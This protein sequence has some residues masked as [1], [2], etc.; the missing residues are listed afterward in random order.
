MKTPKKSILIAF[1][2]GLV[3]FYSCK[4]AETPPNS[5]AGS[6]NFENGVLIANEGAFGSSNGSISYYNPS[7][8]NVTNELFQKINHRPL[9]DVVQSVNRYEESVYI[10]V[11]N[12]NKVEVVNASNFKEEATITGV[13]QPRYMVGYGTTGY[14]SSWNNSGE[15]AII[16]LS[17]NLVS[18]TIP[19]N[20][21]PEKMVIANNQL[22]V[23]N[24]GG[25]DI[26]STI[27]V[28]DLSNNTLKTTITIPAYN[29]T[30][31]VV[32]HNN[33]VW[34]LAKGRTIYDA[35]WNYLGDDPSVLFKINSSTNTIENTINLFATQHPNSLDIS[36]DGSTLYIGGSW[37]FKGIYTVNTSTPTTPTT[38][39]INELCY[40]LLVNSNN[41]NIFLLQEASAAN[42]KLLRYDASGNQLGEYTVGIFPNGG[43]KRNKK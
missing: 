43:S 27:S 3:S 38:P 12:S 21:G 15:I 34:V 25:Y 29:P 39:L 30:A 32:D 18:G 19:V 6:T 4:K 24:S 14:V 17:T 11:N 35:N 7:F 26:D 2:I 8:N 40:G 1:S 37:G 28:I 42:G 13:S 41:G 16:D 5:T 36:P 20:T 9:G 23:M 10:C 33:N 31:A 22:Y